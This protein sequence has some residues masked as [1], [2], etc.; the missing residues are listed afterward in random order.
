[1]DNEMPIS[2]LVQVGTVTDIDNDKH[3]ARV[4]F[5]LTGITSGWLFVL[6]THPHI[7]DFDPAPQQTDEKGG[8]SGEAAFEAHTHPL[9]IKQW[10]PHVNDTVL[11][12]YLPVFN[13]D[14]FVLG[15]I[16]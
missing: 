3:R 14:G 4:K 7:P 10:M 16:S 5:Q 11:C 12:I 6:D 15:G 8:G 13:S 9:T 2:R 1:M